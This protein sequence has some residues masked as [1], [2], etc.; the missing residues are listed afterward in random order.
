MSV[1]SCTKKIIY[2]EDFFDKL[3]SDLMWVNKD[4]GVMEVYECH[5][6]KYKNI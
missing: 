5:T 3:T 6:I 2:I 1:W 4:A